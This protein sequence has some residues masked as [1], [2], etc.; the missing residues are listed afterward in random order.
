[1]DEGK[2]QFLYFRDD[3]H[4]HLHPHEIATQTLDLAAKCLGKVVLI[5]ETVAFQAALKYIFR[6]EMIRRGVNF[7]IVEMNTRTA[8]AARIE[9]LVPYFANGRIIFVKGCLTPETESQF[10]QFPNGRL[11]DVIDSWSMHLKVLRGDKAMRTAIPKQPD[12][13]GWDAV[14]DELQERSKEKSRGLSTGLQNEHASFNFLST[15]LG[16]DVDTRTFVGR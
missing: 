7:D 15:G 10:L 11:V 2:K 3:I 12:P 1:M 4:K 16:L 8:K 13:M 6:D 9:G 14:L 5:I